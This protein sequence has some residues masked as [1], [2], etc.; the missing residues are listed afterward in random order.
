MSAV[1]SA[2][3]RLAAAEVNLTTA[4]AA[5][6]AAST[7]L[8]AISGDQRVIA[9]RAAAARAKLQ[10]LVAVAVTTSGDQLS[11]VLSADSPAQARAKLTS[12]ESITDA[13]S[14]AA[15]EWADRRAEIDGR[16]RQAARR[17][18]DAETV[19]DQMTRVRDLAQTAVDVSTVRLSD[20]QVAA[21]VG[22]RSV[23]DIPNRMLV[24]YVRAAQWSSVVDPTAT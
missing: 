19:V 3:V 23:A 13:A 5:R 16:S 24:A 21:G 2:T 6:D 18:A 12:L 8:D 17:L 4:A 9:A 1:D 10:R 14:D 20:A 11:A 22:P 7:E 15:S